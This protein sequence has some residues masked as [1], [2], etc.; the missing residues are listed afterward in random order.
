MDE[1]LLLEDGGYLLFR[2]DGR[3][4]LEEDQYYVKIELVGEAN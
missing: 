3:L 2:D 4:Q 1:F